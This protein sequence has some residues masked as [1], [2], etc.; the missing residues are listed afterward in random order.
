MRPRPGPLA[1]VRLGAA[2]IALSLTAV[3]T[4]LALVGPA[5]ARRAAAA[6]TATRAPAGASGA[7]IRV[8]GQ[9][10][11]FR[12]VIINGTAYLPMSAVQQALG[13]TVE[14]D[15]I[16]DA[17]AVNG[18]LL[19]AAPR[20]V[21][22]VVYLPAAAVARVLNLILG[23]DVASRTLLFDHSGGPIA[24]RPSPS[25]SLTPRPT[26]TPTAS[27]SGAWRQ[28]FRPVEA[29]DGVFLVTVTDLTELDTVKGYYHPRPGYKFVQVN[30]SQQNVSDALQIYTGR[31]VLSDNKGQA[32][33]PLENLSNFWLVILRPGGINFGYLMYEVPSTAKASRIILDTRDRAPLAVG[34]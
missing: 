9:A 5:S 27:P 28:P 14:W 23:W 1:H 31:F 6:P 8:D 7:A 13:A 30:L 16:T 2:L 4:S 17:V 21:E 24:V 22:G 26:P 33:D 34:L 11:G 32:Y 10:V 20:H 29:T 18:Q 3:L 19:R 12:A 25:P 15:P